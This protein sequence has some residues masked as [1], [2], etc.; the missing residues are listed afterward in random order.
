MAKY[1]RKTELRA[2]A[3]FGELEAA[4][5]ASRGGHGWPTG[6]KPVGRWDDAFKETYCRLCV[7][8]PKLEDKP[9]AWTALMQTWL[10]AAGIPCPNGAFAHGMAVRIGR[11]RSPLG[12]LAYYYHVVVG[13]GYA[14]T[15][16]KLLPKEYLQNPQG[17]KD[18]IVSLIKTYKSTNEPTDRLEDLARGMLGLQPDGTLPEEPIPD[19][20]WEELQSPDVDHDPDE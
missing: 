9:A 4:A 12:S 19:D 11:P 2:E 7:W 3:A 16:K 15:A 8:L 18:R 5:K 10:Q 20:V 6:F 1:E 14:T 13:L 17:T